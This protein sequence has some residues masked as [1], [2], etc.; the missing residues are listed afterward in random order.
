MFVCISYCFLIDKF[1]SFFFFCL[2]LF[3]QISIAFHEAL[4]IT[5]CEDGILMLWQTQ[6]K[7]AV[8][9]DDWTPFVLHDKAR[10][11][12]LV[13]RI[14]VFFSFC[15]VENIML[16]SSLQCSIDVTQIYGELCNV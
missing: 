9:S 8:T 1:Y 15:F 11:L 12:Y 7:S 13:S 16:R 2:I 10:F 6:I 3:L 5:S 14:E 4:I